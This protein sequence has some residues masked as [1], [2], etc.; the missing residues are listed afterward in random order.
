MISSDEENKAQ[1]SRTDC[2]YGIKCYQ[3]N[4]EHIKKYKHP[5]KKR[6][7]SKVSN[8]LIICSIALNSFFYSGYSRREF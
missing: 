2:K 5:L 4:P 7:V 1:F 8:I 3:K 6:K